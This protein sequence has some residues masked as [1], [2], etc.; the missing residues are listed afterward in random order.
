IHHKTLTL[1]HPDGKGRPIQ[2]DC[3]D[4]Y[5]MLRDQ[6]QSETRATRDVRVSGSRGRSLSTQNVRQPGHRKD[7]ASGRSSPSPPSPLFGRGAGGEGPRP[8]PPHPPLALLRSKSSRDCQ[9]V[10]N[11]PRRKV[12]LHRSFWFNTHVGVPCTLCPGA[13]LLLRRWP[14]GHAPLRGI[15]IPRSPCPLFCGDVENFNAIGPPSRL[16]N[17]NAQWHLH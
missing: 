11:T 15:D 4:D 13:F 8:H 12:N 5:R 16:P 2:G 10:G 3:W 7:A 14:S 9:G 6:R 1:C 17:R